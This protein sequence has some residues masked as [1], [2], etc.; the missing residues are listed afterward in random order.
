VKKRQ[1]MAWNWRAV[2]GWWV[3]DAVAEETGVVTNS[4]MTPAGC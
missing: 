3:S 4:E 2:P 1:T